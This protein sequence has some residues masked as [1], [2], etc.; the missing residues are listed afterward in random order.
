M[1]QPAASLEPTEIGARMDGVIRPAAQTPAIAEAFLPSPC[2]QNHAANLTVLPGGDLACVWF[3]GTQEGLSDIDVYMSRLPAGGQQWETPVRLSGDPERSEQN[4]VLFP[5]PDGRLILLHTAQRSGHQDGAIV[6]LR[7]SVDG[8]RSFG[9]AG[10]LPI[11]PGTFVRQPIVVNGRGEWLL[12]VFFCRARPGK[13]WAG[14]DDSSGVLISPDEGRTWRRADVPG[15]LG[16]VHMNIVSLG[17][18]EMVAV[19]RSRYADTIR[20]SRSSDGG[21]SWTA[22]HPLDLPNNNSS[23][24]MIRLRSGRLALIYNH[25]HAGHARERRLS[26]YDDIG[27]ADALASEAAVA[28]E[29]ARPAAFW[30]APRSP[31]GIVT[32]DDAGRSWGEPAVLETG[33]GYCMTNNSKD[34][35]N[36]EFSYPSIVQGEDGTI[37]VAF[38]Y[39]RQAIKYLRIPEAL[40]SIPSRS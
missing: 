33:S 17:G 23:I 2:P 10:T 34:R 4:P 30:G 7:I 14:E 32:S 35:L 18:D 1:I 28:G 12:P 11:E 6:R 29:Q 13:A 3:G 39:Y 15:S 20:M 8:G 21:S 22:P 40:L 16:A 5:A 31:L 37:H 36:R 26:L 24:Q 19:Y 38:T 25:S 27:E 9:A